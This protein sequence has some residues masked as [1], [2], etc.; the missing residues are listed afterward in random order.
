M[1]GVKWC[2]PHAAPLPQAGPSPS[3]TPGCCLGLLWSRF[4]SGNGSGQLPLFASEALQAGV[5]GFSKCPLLSL[6]SLEMGLS[7][8]PSLLAGLF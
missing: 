5:L 1:W 3:V 2:F 6:R 4:C 7:R 8:A